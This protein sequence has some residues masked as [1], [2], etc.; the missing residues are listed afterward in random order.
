METPEA[1]QQ[2]VRRE[3]QMI[4]RR[5]LAMTWLADA[6]RARIWALVVAQEA[7]LSI[8]QIA[9]PPACV[10]PGFLSCFR[11]TKRVRSPCSSVSSKTSASH[12][13]C[14]RLR[15]D[16]TWD[17]SQPYNLATH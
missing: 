3:Q 1:L 2:C 9:L 12:L 7:G 15:S 11:Q 10:R 14:R 6:E 4:A 8:R 16:L 13:Q 5:R 17:D